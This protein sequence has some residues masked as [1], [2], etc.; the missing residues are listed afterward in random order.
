MSKAVVVRNVRIGDDIPKIAVSLM[1]IDE[2]ELAGEIEKL[3]N[4]NFD[5]V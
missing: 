3:N 5:I 4:I 1:G 2:S